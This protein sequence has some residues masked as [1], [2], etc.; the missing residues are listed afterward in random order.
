MGSRILAV[1]VRNA[2]KTFGGT[3]AVNNLNLSVEPELRP[4]AAKSQ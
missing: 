4:S 3:R 2:S 1:E